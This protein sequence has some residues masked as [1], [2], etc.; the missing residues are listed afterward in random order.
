L[1]GREYEAVREQEVLSSYSDTAG[2]YIPEGTKQM[3]IEAQTTS[4]AS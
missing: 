4:R 2:A 1:R 3:K